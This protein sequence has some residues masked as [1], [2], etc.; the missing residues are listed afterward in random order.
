MPPFLSG[1]FWRAVFT[2]TRGE[3]LWAGHRRASGGPGCRWDAL[4]GA[5]VLRAEPD[6]FGGI[7]VPLERFRALDRLD[8]ASFQKV[9]QAA[10]QQWRSEGRI[11]VWLHIPILQSQFIAPAASLGF[12]FHHAESDSSTL[13][14]W[15]GEGPSRLP[16]YATHQVGVAGAVFDENTRK[17][18]V[19]QDRNKML[20][21]GRLFK[22]VFL[23]SRSLLPIWEGHG[24][25]KD[26]EKYVEVP[27]RPVRAWRRYWCVPY[28]FFNC[29][30]KFRKFLCLLFSS[31]AENKILNFLRNFRGY[32]RANIKLAAKLVILQLIP[33]V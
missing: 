19:V 21:I 9:L 22:T 32:F 13:T 1:R 31:I 20:R 8:A 14:L 27:R 25:T 23:M 6:R 16:G 11:A 30:K 4:A 28:I 29:L 12:C 17:I 18:L 33:L 10:I 5:D 24:H 2:R 26:V 3:R 7:S 15:L